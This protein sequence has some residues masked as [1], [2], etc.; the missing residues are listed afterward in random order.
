MAKTRAKPLN[1]ASDVPVMLAGEQPGISDR[2]AE[3]IAYIRAALNEGGEATDWKCSVYRVVQGNSARTENYLFDCLPLELL[4]VR[5]RV[6]GEYGNGRYRARVLRDLVPFKQFDFNIELSPTAARAFADRQRQQLESTAGAPAPIA[7]NTPTAT[8]TAILQTLAQQGQ[9]LAAIAAKLAAPPPPATNALKD[10]LEN[11]TAM[12]QLGILPKPADP[13]ETFAKSLELAEK[14]M[15]AAGGK[16]ETSL[17][18][19]AREALP[20]LTVALQNRNPAPAALPAPSPAPAPISLPPRVAPAANA[21]PTQH[22]PA[23][24]IAPTLD[25]QQQAQMAAMG[26]DLNQLAMVIGHCLNQARAGVQPDLLSDWVGQRVPPLVFDYLEQ[27][28]DPVAALGQFFPDVNAY[29]PWFTALIASLYESGDDEPAGEGETAR[30][31]GAAALQQ[32]G[33]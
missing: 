31:G 13:A 19:L 3:A 11:F 10:M 33:G 32:P 2:E 16:T 9:V 30:H 15:Q 29:R 26:L 22:A 20:A 17:L 24:P 6:M 23:A 5:E 4:T 27:Q 8:E 25:A 7:A 12:Q 1:A 28:P 14:M 18:D 21:P